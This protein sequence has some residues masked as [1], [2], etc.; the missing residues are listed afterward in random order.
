MLQLI[1]IRHANAGPYTL[2]DE[3]RRLSEKGILQT[4]SLALK[5]DSEHFP[6]GYWLISNANRALETAQI[7]VENRP[8]IG[9]EIDHLWYAA[10]GSVYMQMLARQTESVIYL[11]AHNPSISHVASYVMGENLQVKTADCLHF[12]WP[13]LDSWQMVTLGSAEMVLYF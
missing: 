6:V 7:L 13:N 2:P 8:I 9:Q 10:S 12:R 4:H 5:L 1:L 11:V 3:T